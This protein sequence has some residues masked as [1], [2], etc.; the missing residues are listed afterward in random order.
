MKNLRGIISRG[1]GVVVFLAL[2]CYLFIHF[3]YVFREPL[4]HTAEHMMGFYSEEENTIDVVILGT[5]CTFSAIAPMCLW[6][7]CGIPAYDFCTNVMLEDTMKYAVREIAKTQA[8]KL[9]MVDIAPFMNG[10]YSDSF[11]Q[12]NQVARYNTD[13]FKISMN[14]YHLINDILRNKDNKM[15]NYFDLLYYHSNPEPKIKNWN[16]NSPSVCKGYSNLQIEVMFEE[17]LTESDDLYSGYDISNEEKRI[18]EDFLNEID[19]NNFD[20]LFFV[21]PYWPVEDKNEA[22]GKARRIQVYLEDRGYTFLNMHEYLDEIGMNGMEDYSMDYN[23]Y[24]I[25]GAL[26]ISEFLGDYLCSHYDL[27][28]KREDIRYDKWRREFQEWKSVNL[29]NDISW[30]DRLRQEYLKEHKDNT[31]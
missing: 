25:H 4:S 29:Q 6:E 16:W 8:P 26:K 13:G 22:I 23:H 3:T 28:D 31:K 1:C 5:S 27:S 11:G 18:L 24:N 30:T 14:R 10:Y 9:L 15:N 19:E 12:D 17:K 20:V 21:G 7:N 2:F